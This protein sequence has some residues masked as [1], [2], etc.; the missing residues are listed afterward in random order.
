MAFLIG[1]VVFFLAV[2]LTVILGGISRFGDRRVE[3]EGRA[4]DGQRL[5]TDREAHGY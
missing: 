2:A 1:F 4:T 5:P 3:T